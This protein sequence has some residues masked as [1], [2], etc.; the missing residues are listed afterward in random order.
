MALEK[1][2]GFDSI[3]ELMSILHD[4]SISRNMRMLS[5][6][7]F[8]NALELS[9]FNSRRIKKVMDDHKKDVKEFEKASKDCKDAELK[10]FADR[11]LPVLKVHLDS[12]KAITG[13]N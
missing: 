13:K 10:S 8:S 11:T 4:L 2:H 3:L 9:N 7:S 12:A 1:K 6:A 5:D